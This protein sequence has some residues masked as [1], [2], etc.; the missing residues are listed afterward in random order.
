M[1][2]TQV[3]LPPIPGGLNLRDQPDHVDPQYAIDLSNIAYGERGIVGP[4]NGYG[5]WSAVVPGSGP[6]TTLAP[7]QTTGGTKQILAGDA[8]Q[9]RA[10]DSSGAIVSTAQAFAGRHSVARFG[11]PT[12]EAGF[13]ASEANSTLIYWNGAAWTLAPAFTLNGGANP[14]GK[15]VAVTPWD[16]RLVNANFSGATQGSNK[17]SVR[18]SKEGDPLSWNS[19]LWFEDLSP[20]DGEQ[21]TAMIAWRESR[22]VFKETKFFRFYGT[23]SDAA[24]N[25]T[26]DYVT[27]NTG[28]G[29]VGPKAVCANSDYLYFVSPRGVYRTKGGEPEYVSDLIEPL[30]MG[31]LPDAYLGNKIN[32]SYLDKINMHAA[33]ER[34]Y[35]SVPTGSSST[36]DSIIVHSPNEKWWTVWALPSQAMCGVPN[37]N[38]EDQLLICPSSLIKLCS[39]AY[40]DDQGTP[41]SS[42]LKFAFNDFGDPSIK[43][44]RECKVWGKGKIRFSLAKDFSDSLNAKVIDWSTGTTDLWGDGTGSD[45]WGDGTGPDL[46]STPP[47][48]TPALFRNAVRGTFFSVQIQD[49]NG[50]SWQLDRVTHNLR[51]KLTPSKTRVDVA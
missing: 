49:V 12:L 25:P 41:I 33:A 38:A 46:W 51:G 15:L 13:V 31:A 17:S 34:I 32:R 4:R 27:I 48:V 36:C 8:T 20:G 26:F 45:T 3:T 47:A 42:R 2:Y 1:A 10:I 30:F 14:N 29:C 35:I 11:G 37:A 24:G 44:V 19:A 6:Y 9:I 16:N 22:F 28:I 7:F 21:I 43:V 50:A 39:A 5:A 23:T 40:T 18:F